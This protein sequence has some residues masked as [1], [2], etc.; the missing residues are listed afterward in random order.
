MGSE[1][2]GSVTGRAG[3]KLR[4]WGVSAQELGCGERKRGCGMTSAAARGRRR[5]GRAAERSVWVGAVGGWGV[6][7]KEV[8]G[9]GECGRGCGC[10]VLACWCRWI[11]NDPLELCSD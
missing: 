7:W 9:C 6:R 1:V 4:G 11:C 3:G 2:A 5:M 10:V 8:R